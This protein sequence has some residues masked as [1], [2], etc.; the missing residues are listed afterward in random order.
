MRSEVFGREMGMGVYAGGRIGY[1]YGEGT[2]FVTGHGVRRSIS[3]KI[4]D[5]AEQNTI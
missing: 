5:T 3:F 4:I 1:G 2:C